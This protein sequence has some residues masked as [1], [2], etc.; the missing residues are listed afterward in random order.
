MTTQKELAKAT[1][2]WP[3]S[4]LVEVWNQLP[5]VAPVRRFT[6][7]TEI[8]ASFA[9]PAQAASRAPS[10]FPVNR[11]GLRQCSQPGQPMNLS[12]TDPDRAPAQED[13]A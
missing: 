9:S 8:S 11:A 10:A 5:G 4:K 6:D 1:E 7:R 13:R 3:A 12:R 2:Q